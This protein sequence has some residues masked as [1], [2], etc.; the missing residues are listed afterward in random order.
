MRWVSSSNAK[1]SEDSRVTQR[2]CGNERTP[3]KLCQQSCAES[4]NP[5]YLGEKE[6]V[7][8][9]ITEADNLF[10]EVR[11]EN[12]WTDFDGQPVALKEGAFLELTFEAKAAEADKA[13]LNS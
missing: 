10:R 9:S 12:Q 13:D 7:E 11:I 8:I 5:F 3:G 4:L 6:W 1:K 2:L